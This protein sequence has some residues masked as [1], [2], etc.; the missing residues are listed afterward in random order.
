MAEFSKLFEPGR[1]GTMLV[2]NRIV[3]AAMGTHSADVDGQINDRTIDYYEARAKGGVGL[4]I[5]QGMSSRAEARRPHKLALYDD[6]F[7]P[8]L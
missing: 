1:I 7:I 3:M 8:R 2:R 4:I 5:T 6:R